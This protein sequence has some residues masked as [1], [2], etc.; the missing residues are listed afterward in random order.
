LKPNIKEEYLHDNEP[1]F[2]PEFEGF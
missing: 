2:R 1:Q